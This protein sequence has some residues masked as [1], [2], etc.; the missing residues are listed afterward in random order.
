MT[1]PAT[2]PLPNGRLE[3]RRRIRQSARSVFLPPPVL[4]VS[5]WADQYRRLPSVSAEPGQWRTSRAPYLKRIMDV[6]GSERVREVVFCKSSQVGGSSCAENLVG[7]LMDQ[8]PCAILEVWPTQEMM[9]DWSLTR[10]T[11]MIEA[12]P[13]LNAK[14]IRSGRRESDDS[15]AYKAFLGGW[16]KGLTAKSTAA[17]RAASARVAIAEEVDEWV[18]DLKGQGDPLELLRTRL[19]TFYN[20]L[21]FINS[22]PTLQGYSRVW[23]ELQRSTWEE[24]F[25]PCPHCGTFQTL[26]WRDGD[27]DPDAVGTYRLI[28]ERDDEGLAIDGTVKYVCEQGCLIDEHD[29]EAMVQTHEWRAKFPGR[30]MVGFHINTLYSLLCPWIEVVR[31]FERGLA[32]AESLK[33]FVNTFLGLPYTP[34]GDSIDTHV[35]KSRAIA[36]PRRAEGETSVELIPASVGLLTAGVDVQGDRLELLVWGWGAGSS[37]WLIAWEQLYGDP[38]QP[39]V[40]AELE[41]RRIA[42][43]PHEG[44]GW[45]SIAAMC[46]DAGYMPDKVHAYCDARRAQRVLA[47]IGKG[48][49]GRKLLEAPDAQKFKR[50]GKKRPTHMV[51]SDSGKSL[52]MSA[53]RVPPGAPGEVRFP[54][55]VDPVFYDQLTSNKQVTRLREGKYV[56]VWELVPGRRDD[57]LDGSVYAEAALTLMGPNIRS[58]LLQYVEGINAAGEAMKAGRLP[59]VAVRAGRRILSRGIE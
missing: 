43:R 59:A 11:P 36:Y 12:T 19:R 55:S 26:R 45:L 52:L 46:V 41:R 5:E 8:A 21:L 18:G 7:Y 56:R 22:T 40:W 2:A 51:G 16:I 17:L 58:Q 44:G 30:S 38:G 29:K 50:A 42:Q 54:D 39:D 23:R 35:L 6:L 53:L 34:K 32:N 10:L 57:T 13:V 3:L 48:G 4:T 1:A 47:I 20:G 27:E 49:P 28:W 9:K 15:I 24:C 14:F 25:V 31:A 37:R 33:N